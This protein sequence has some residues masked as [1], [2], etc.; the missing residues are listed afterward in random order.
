MD[1]SE[2][3]IPVSVFLQLEPQRHG[4]EALLKRQCAMESKTI[5]EWHK[6]IDSIL[7]RRA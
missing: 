5:A 3:R 7:K 1:N 2:K 6:T 4:V